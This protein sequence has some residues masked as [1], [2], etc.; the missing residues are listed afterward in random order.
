MKVILI[1]A[2]FIVL[3]FRNCTSE[4]VTQCISNPTGTLEF[5][6][7]I[8][9][10]PGAE[11]PK[12]SKGEQGKQGAIGPQGLLGPP[13]ITGKPG[14]SG[15]GQKGD[16]GIQ[17]VKG[18]RGLF[19]RNGSKG[20]VGKIGPKGSQGP[21]GA[22][23]PPGT[24]GSKGEKGQAGLQGAPGSTGE[25][26]EPG[27]TGLR[28]PAGPQGQPGAQ[29]TPGDTTLTNEEFERVITAV[30]QNL[31]W[32][33]LHVK[34]NIELL[35]KQVK[36]MKSAFT[37]CGQ[38][39][40]QWRRVAYINTENGANCSSNLTMVDNGQG[41]SACAS[42]ANT[43]CLSVYFYSQGLYRQVC[44]RVR[45]YQLGTPE[46]FNK[47]LTDINNAYLHGV[48]ITH[49]APREHLWSYVA[50]R[51]EDAK[52]QDRCPCARSDPNSKEGIPEFVQDH[53]FCE[54]GYQY[55][56]E[57]SEIVSNHQFQWNDPLWD[58]SGCLNPGNKCCDTDGWFLRTI[59]TTSNNLEVRWCVDHRTTL[60]NVATDIVEIWVAP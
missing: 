12:G 45:G 18:E 20:S 25:R 35:H 10:V 59:P 2:V 42:S 13:G 16:R 26:G 23:G 50:G 31:T 46:G 27:R 56:N 41:K 9:G 37:K 6:A 4:N 5:T 29:G 34:L 22:V 14:N 36:D 49:G 32:D 44:G 47:Q 48:S 7:H 40:T 55:A 52:L 58:G 19:G 57:V 1:I 17:G 39:N 15:Q 3:F 8:L 30:H 28:G 54:S 21:R 24:A 43:G 33:I 53:Y 51:A 38:Y 60:E 11:G